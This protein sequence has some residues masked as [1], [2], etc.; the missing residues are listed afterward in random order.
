MW[1]MKIWW[2]IWGKVQKEKK[3]ESKIY[4]G[5]EPIVIQRM[6]GPRGDWYLRLGVLEAESELEIQD[7]VIY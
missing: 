1:S 7:R 3:S 6:V 4:L 5:F 2:L